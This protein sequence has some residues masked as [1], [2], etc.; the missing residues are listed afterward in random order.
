MDIRALEYLLSASAAT[1]NCL[2]L[3]IKSDPK[4]LTIASP[5]FSGMTSGFFSTYRHAHAFTRPG[6]RVNGS[7]VSAVVVNYFYPARGRL[8]SA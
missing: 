6:G 7:V 4:R 5:D 1:L 8:S 2:S 3:R